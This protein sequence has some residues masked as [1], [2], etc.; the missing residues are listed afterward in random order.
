MNS[1]ATPTIRPAKPPNPKCH[2]RVNNQTMTA[3]ISKTGIQIMKSSGTLPIPIALRPTTGTV[4]QANEIVLFESGSR[5]KRYPNTTA[6]TGVPIPNASKVG[7][8]GKYTGSDLGVPERLRARPNASTMN[9]AMAPP[10]TAP[11]TVWTD[12]PNFDTIFARLS[13]VKKYTLCPFAG[14][15]YSG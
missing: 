4:V 14:H 13:G 8:S 11:A 3:P 7:V 10:V 15:P 5:E 1:E 2:F 6:P 9:A 12:R